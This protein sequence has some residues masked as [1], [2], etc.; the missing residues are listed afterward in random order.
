M[1]CLDA[2]ELDLRYLPR[3]QAVKHKAHFKEGFTASITNSAML[4]MLLH[5]CMHLGV[6]C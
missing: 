6:Y 4:S 5:Y 1:R 2:S 3:H